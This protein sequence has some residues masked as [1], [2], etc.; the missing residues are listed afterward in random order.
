[1]K[2]IFKHSV[3][4]FSGLLIVLFL[5]VMGTVVSAADV[6][7]NGYATILYDND[8]TALSICHGPYT[9]IDRKRLDQWQACDDAIIQIK[10]KESGKKHQYADCLSDAGK[11]FRVDGNVF[12][13]R[14]FLMTYPEF[15]SQPLLV[16]SL[17]LMTNKKTY[18]FEKQFPVCTKKDISDAANQIDSVTVKPFEG[19]TYFNAVYS[20]LYTLRDCAKS[21]PELVISILRRY[22]TGNYFD[23]EVEETLNSVVDE[24][25]LIGAATQR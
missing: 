8:K 21:N 24:V 5:F 15:E 19:K 18:R 2:L 23:G 17:D 11:E 16:E 1:M 7:C 3:F 22:R 9:K 20:N 13:L 25:E 4:E 14:H 6:T 12:M 10:D